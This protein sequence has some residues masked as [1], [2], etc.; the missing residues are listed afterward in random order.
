MR[1]KSTTTYTLNYKINVKTN[2]LIYYD[3]TGNHAITIDG[4][5]KV[6]LNNI[7]KIITTQ[8]ISEIYIH[9]F[10]K[11]FTKKVSFLSYPITI[12]I[13][14]EGTYLIYAVTKNNT[15]LNLS[16]YVS[17]SYI[18]PYKS[19]DSNDIRPPQSDTSIGIIEL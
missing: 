10:E 18:L 14:T 6:V 8:N 5:A 4:H 9:H 19:N 2:N 1:I 16:P 3:Y 11:N 13:T 12:D 17:I 15:F 7:N